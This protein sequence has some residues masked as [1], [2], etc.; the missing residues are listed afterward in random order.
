M[1][2]KIANI[3][4]QSIY[5]AGNRL[6]LCCYSLEEFQRMPNAV[7]INNAI[8]YKGDFHPYNNCVMY[9]GNQ[10]LEVYEIEEDGCTHPQNVLIDSKIDANSHASWHPLKEIVE[11]SFDPMTIYQVYSFIQEKL[12]NIKI[13]FI[14]NRFFFDEVF[15]RFLYFSEDCKCIRYTNFFEDSIITVDEA[16]RLIKEHYTFKNFK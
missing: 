1:K 15:N 16:I 9:E 11:K 12:P 4:I 14:D 6:D 5:I 8:Y 10:Q 2:P 13:P 7:S 3:K